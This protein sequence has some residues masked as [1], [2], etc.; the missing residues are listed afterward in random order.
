MHH[1]IKADSEVLRILRKRKRLNSR[2]ERIVKCCR[3]DLAKN[4]RNAVIQNTDN[5]ISSNI[6]L[7]TNLHIFVIIFLHNE[8]KIV[9]LR[10]DKIFK[11]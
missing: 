4:T 6:F 5:P 3:M 9:I 2:L 1:T 8:K 10:I 11:S 7:F